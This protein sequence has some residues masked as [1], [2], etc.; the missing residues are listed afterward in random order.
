MTE[1]SVPTRVPEPLE[2]GPSPWPTFAVCATAAYVTTLDMSIVNVA[3]PEIASSFPDASRGMIS[4]VVTAYS[5]LFGSLLVASGRMADQVGRKRMLQAGITL[6]LLGSAGC[7]L[8]PGLGA[9]IAGRAVQGLGGALMMP[10]SLGLLLSAFPAERRSQ[11]IAWNGAAGALGV[12][13]GPTLGALL[14]SGFGWRSAFW[15]NIPI[16][17]GLAVMT[18]RS[19]HEPPRVRQPRPD[20]GAAVLV[21]AAVAALVGGISRAESTGWTDAAVIGLL[22]AAGVLGGMVVQRS[23]R[24]PV[25]L[26]PPSLFR[27]RSFTA[28]NIA[29]FVFGAAFAANILNNVLFLRTVWDYSVITAGLFSVLA[30]VVV[31]ITAFV[32]G[33]TMGRVGFRPLLIAAQISFAVIVLG[34]ALLLS[35][36]P[37]PWTRWLPLMVVL[38]IAIGFTF[39]VLSAAAVSTL[40]PENFALGGAVNNTFRQVG[41][42]V[43]VA[44]VVTLQSSGD[45]IDGFRA[46]WYFVAVCGLIAAAACM[47]Q[48]RASTEG[49]A[50]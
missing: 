39:P 2:R 50:T 27:E 34:E 6:F 40:R 9:L 13:S 31:A 37:T 41:S 26:I 25:P 12:S 8:S 19:V 3:F 42:A 10:A 1:L 4:W 20:I 14:V 5:I 36:D 45:G 15:I 21:T 11:A 18:R 48:P 28:A 38:G 33:R 17:I 49:I 24:H 46:G 23:L 35:S 7:A 47:L 44:L 32:A 16:C 22:V 29:T 30:P 43:G